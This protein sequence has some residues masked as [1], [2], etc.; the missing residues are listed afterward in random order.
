MSTN[1]AIDFFECSQK[2]QFFLHT[3]SFPF[4]KKNSQKTL[5]WIEVDRV[6]DIENIW[7]KWKDFW[8]AL[9]I[10]TVHSIRTSLLIWSLILHATIPLKVTPQ[11]FQFLSV[12]QNS[13]FDNHSTILT[14]WI[15]SPDGVKFWMSSLL[16]LQK[17][18]R[19]IKLPY[20]HCWWSKI[21]IE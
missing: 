16:W 17:G 18:K 4:N 20:Y 8:H 12:N 21:L 5:E 19:E 6:K 9:F 13:F 3:Y 11:E 2:I 15:G 14:I 1:A 10:T 7:T